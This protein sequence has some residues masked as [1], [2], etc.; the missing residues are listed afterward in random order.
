MKYLKAVIELEATNRQV[1]K[2]YSHIQ[3][4][5][6]TPN[7]KLVVWNNIQK[8]DILSNYNISEEQIITL[9][10]MIIGK[11]RGS[12]PF[13]PVYDNSATYEI[14]SDALNDHE[15]LQEKYEQLQEK[16]NKLEN[17]IKAFASTC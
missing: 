17:K 5:V 10:D 16:Y 7:S 13:I 2:T 1:G 11:V 14:C 6:N 8:N 15:I 9:N 12:K 3:L 4:V